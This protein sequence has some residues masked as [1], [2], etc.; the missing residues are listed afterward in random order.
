[1]Q[2]TASAPICSLSNSALSRTSIRRT[3]CS[4]IYERSSTGNAHF[5]FGSD[6]F[7]PSDAEAAVFGTEGRLKPGSSSSSSIEGN[8]CVKPV[9]SKLF[10][11]GDDESDGDLKVDEGTNVRLVGSRVGDSELGGAGGRLDTS[12]EKR[13]EVV[14]AEPLSCKARSRSAMV[15][16]DLIL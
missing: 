8:V 15:P 2:T 6:V 16:P 11:C 3:L 10:S 5:A 14:T 9:R 4:R 13:L 1:M 12:G 7:G